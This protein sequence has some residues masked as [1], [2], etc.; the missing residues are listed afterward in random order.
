M[1]LLFDVLR[2]VRV[3]LIF[4]ALW[5]FLLLLSCLLISHAFGCGLTNLGSVRRTC[6]LDGLPGAFN[7]LLDVLGHL[8][9]G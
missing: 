3:Y 2:D 6:S 1:I 9:L 7:A 5:A 4:K 8:R